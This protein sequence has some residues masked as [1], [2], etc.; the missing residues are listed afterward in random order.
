[1]LGLARGSQ[2]VS[3]RCFYKSQETAPNHCQ[4]VSKAGNWPN[5]AL[6]FFVP[7][8]SSRTDP[9]QDIADLSRW[10][11]AKFGRA[12]DLVFPSPPVT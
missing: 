3:Q 5:L 9:V 10:P 12:L 7:V 8:A 6:R 4:Q 1:V 11:P 2:R